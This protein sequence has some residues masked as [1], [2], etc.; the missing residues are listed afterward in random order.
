M[1][2]KDSD[3][4]ALKNSQN[5]EEWNAVCD[6]VKKE[7][8]GNYPTDWFEKVLRSGVAGD[9]QERWDNNRKA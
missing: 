1:L 4:N 2:L 7:G 3:L 9:A 6:R 5:E 8:G